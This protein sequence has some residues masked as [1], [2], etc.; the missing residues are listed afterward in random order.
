MCGRHADRE[1]H[2][3]DRLLEGPV[4]AADPRCEFKFPKTEKDIVVRVQSPL[5]E[6][7]QQP[8]APCRPVI[9]DAIKLE[10][11]SLDDTQTFHRIAS[12]L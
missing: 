12:L 3:F 8:T 4:P 5:G 6:Q 2:L 11:P 9:E 7:L 10:N 1:E